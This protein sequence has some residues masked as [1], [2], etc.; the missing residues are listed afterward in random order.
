MFDIVLALVLLVLGYF[1]LLLEFAIPS[2]GL[3]TIVALVLLGFGLITLAGI[4]D[5]WVVVVVGTTSFLAFI[6]LLRFL[7]KSKVLNRL[8]IVLDEKI[9]GGSSKVATQQELTGKHGVAVSDLRPSGIVEIEGKRHDVVTDAGDY[10]ESGSKVIV[11][12]ISTNTVV[13]EKL[14]DEEEGGE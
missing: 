6:V 5:T 8:G 9:R 14:L 7:M 11:V 10:I 1:V 3:L 4:V 2:F 12:R 13:V